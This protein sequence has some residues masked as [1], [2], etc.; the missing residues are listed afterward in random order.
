[1]AGEKDKIMAK[2]DLDKVPE[3][4]AII[5]D[6]N[7]RWARKKG[8]PRIAGHR[9]GVESI[10]EVIETSLELNIKVITLFAF[11]TENWKR[12]RKEVNFLMNLPLEYLN[13]EL[14]NLK[15]QGV[16]INKIG[17][18]EDIPEKTLNAV[19]KGIK[20]TYNNNKLILNFALNYGGR[21][22]IINAVK[23]IADKVENKELDSNNIDE[24][25]FNE[26]LY[27]K[28]LPDPSL[29]IRS[30]GEKR[31]S[32]FL[33]W[34]MAYSELWFSPVYWPDFKGEHLLEAIYDYQNRDRR[35]GKV[36]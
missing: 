15:K 36:K 12:P 20:E 11:S 21:A 28:D 13:K 10:R 35:F 8:L 3:H 23:R 14:D 30:S 31:I 5:M 16:K 2:I 19:K 17:C 26:Y 9:A 4:I 27:T 25:I 6:G 34:Q 7:G 33:L 1:M 18:E 32:N 22:E 24:N 29:I